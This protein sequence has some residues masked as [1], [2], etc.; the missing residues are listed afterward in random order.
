MKATSGRRPAIGLALAL[1]LCLTLA[2]GEARADGPADVIVLLNAPAPPSGASPALRFAEVRAA[3]GAVLAS[4]GEGIAVTYEYRAIPAF[5]ARA[6]AG[7]IQRLEADPRVARV[8][9]DRAG[10]GHDAESFALIHASGAQALGYTGSGVTVAVIDSGVDRGHPDFAGAVSHEECFMAAPWLASRCPDGSGRQSGPGAGQDGLGHGTSVAG[11]VLGRG[12]LAPKGMA[13]GATLQV[14]KVLDDANTFYFSDLYAAVDHIAA[15]HPEV[16][17]INMSLGSFEQET[18]ATCNSDPFFDALSQSGVVVFASSGNQRFKAG[19]G[20]PACVD[21]VISVGAVYDET[22]A[23][24]T[25]FGC[26]DAPAQVDNVPCWSNSDATLDLLGPGCWITGPGNGSPTSTY[27]GT[28]QAAPHAAGLAALLLEQQPL[29]APADIEVILKRSGDPVADPANG[30]TTRRID[31][32]AAVTRCLG[33]A[34]ASTTGCVTPTPTA[35]PTP[36]PTPSPTPTGQLFG[37]ADCNWTL[38]TGDA[39]AIIR[40]EAAVAGLPCPDRAD[41]DCD[42]GVDIGD[43]MTLFRFWAGLLAEL[44]CASAPSPPVEGGF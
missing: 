13:P 38:D 32:L 19:M 16:D 11:I 5:A 10:H 33:A 2:S 1:V 34:A 22:S 25:F 8:V 40:S 20:Y 23:S 44:G 14:Y 31:A 36:S 43:A 27:C 30:V 17:V 15:V 24:R 28:S 7:A 39:L 18:Q 3:Q 4:A 21:T 35:P 6:S 37:D 29:A 26:T 12:V 42:G 41:V 9:R